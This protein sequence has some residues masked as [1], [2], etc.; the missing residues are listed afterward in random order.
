MKCFNIDLD[1]VKPICMFDVTNEEEIKQFFCWQ[2]NS[3]NLKHENQ[4]IGSKFTFLDYE[5][6]CIK[7]YQFIKL[8][9]E[10]LNGNFCRWDI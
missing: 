4:Q 6:Q 10:G 1:H 9:E 7:A 3:T 2:K 5:L 8:K